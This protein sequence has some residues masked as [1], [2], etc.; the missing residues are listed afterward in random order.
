MRGLTQRL[1]YIDDT[2]LQSIGRHCNPGNVPL[3]RGFQAHRQRQICD[4]NA[5]KYQTSPA[6]IGLPP[7]RSPM[8]E[9]LFR[10]T[11]KS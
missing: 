10:R 1:D 7:A 6:A 2:G 4:M 8:V 5:G 9:K 3:D 11:N